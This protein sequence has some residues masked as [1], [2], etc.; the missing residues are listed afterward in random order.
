MASGPPTD[1]L[2]SAGLLATL[3][4]LV[5]DRA[6]G[7]VRHKKGI[8]VFLGAGAD[9]S[10]GGLSF[11]D[12]KRQAVEEFTGRRLFDVT[13]PEQTEARF[14]ELFERQAPDDRAL[15]IESLFRRLHALHPSDSYKLLVLTAEAGGIDAVVTTNFDLM[16]E[17]AQSLLGRDVF[18]VFGPGV[19]RPYMVSHARYE[20]ARKPYIKL[21][22]DLA[23][24][25]VTFLTTEELDAADYDASILELFRS[26]LQTHDLILAGYGGHDRALSRIISENI[27]ND[28]R[29]YWCNPRL[30]AT[31][32]P[33]Y[34]AL[35][36]RVT[37]I[38]VAFDQLMAMVARPVLERP[39]LASS[40]PTYIRC[41]FDWRVDFCNREY[42]QTYAYHD[43]RLQTDSFAR[44]TAIES[45]LTEFLRPNHPLALISGPS[46]FGKS[47]IGLRLLKIWTSD[48]STSLMLIRSR[49]LGDNLDLEQ[50]IADQ[51][52]GL[53][54]RGPFTLFHLERWLREQDRRLIL[55]VDAINE[56]STDFQRCLQFFRAILRICYFLPEHESAIR[57]IATM[58]QETWHSMLPHLDMVQLRRALWTGESSETAITTVACGPFTDEELADAM[59]RTVGH[60]DAPNWNLASPAALRALHDPYLF[61]IL[62]RGSNL[63]VASAVG[64]NIVQEALESRLRRRGSL[65]DLATL[66][67]TLAAIALATLGTKRD[68]FREV[69]IEPA[70]LRAELLRLVRDLGLVKDAGDGFLQFDHDRTYEYFLAVG[71]TGSA[72]V[73][74]ETLDDLRGFLARFHTEARVVAAARLYYQLAPA[75]RFP[76]LAPA[77]GL[78]DKENAPLGVAD[79]ERLFEF[80]RDVLIE[81]ADA[82]EPLAEQYLDD[83]VDAARS[84]RIGTHQLRTVVRASARLPIDD[85][86]RLLTQAAHPSAALAGTEATILATDIL[87]RSFFRTKSEP[88]NLLT[89]LPFAVFFNDQTIRPW[90]RFGRLL[91][92]AT[93]IGPDNAHEVEYSGFIQAWHSALDS[94][95]ED[96]P[97]SS[98]DVAATTDFIIANCDRLLFNATPGGI[99]RFFGNPRRADLLVIVD[100]L[101]AGGTVTTQDLAAFEP[102][103]QSLASDIEY[104]LSHALVILSSLNDWDATI[105]VIETH[106]SMLT[107]STAPEEIDFFHAAL[108]YLHVLHSRS[109]DEARFRPWEEVILR[110]WPNV[111]L[112]RPGLERGERRGFQDPFDRVFEDGFGVVYAYGSLLPSNH[113]KALQYAEYR[114]ELSAQRGSPLPMYSAFLDAYLGEGRIDEAV[115]LLQALAGIVVNWP[116]EGLLALRPAI[117]FPDPRIRRA[118]LRVLAE[119]FQRHPAETSEFL[120]SAG[121]ALTDD[122]IIDITIRQDARVGRRQIEEHEWARLGHALLRRPGGKELFVRCLRALLAATSAPTAIHAILQELGLADR[123]GQ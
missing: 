85:A 34:S 104:H 101:A 35:A 98:E 33:L 107:R 11:A 122:D 39:T 21:H 46:G 81:M 77:L 54:S 28:T 14:E 66:K 9:L 86:I 106:Y 102:Y 50:Y 22:G 56:F 93:Q 74:L 20:L 68:R 87:V 12:L 38:V 123:T 30:P 19:A 90:Q 8:C 112:Y 36:G 5:A 53:G 27:G 116:T 57:I 115:Q 100:R 47:T 59:R 48:P 64:A 69:D 37:P 96:A 52:G 40:E 120:R 75:K 7:T 111:L 10:S 103:T 110:Q 3:A 65:I 83:A 45:R 95:L 92:F 63:S 2:D 58:R 13:T 60:S 41:L 55:F 97:W 31:N 67:E 119:A 25:S 26:V 49:A 91:W 84:A 42:V 44:R 114:R 73:H 79:R 76:V 118:T 62:A 51:L 113:R 1:T 61:G 121:T 72:T 71:L 32:A 105:R 29:V 43:G 17:R 94:L 109:Y 15:L 23:S 108:V 6:T 24:R 78:L 82:K 88:V 117:G 80:A 89:D 4:R 16:L 70:A 99:D 18:Q